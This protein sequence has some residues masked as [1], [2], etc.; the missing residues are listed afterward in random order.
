MTKPIS[1]AI[2][3][4]STLPTR[5]P[6]PMC[7]SILYRDPVADPDGAKKM[8][9]THLALARWMYEQGYKDLLKSP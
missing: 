7:H 8:L 9:E 6:V 1:A 2:C 3:V 4:C 5:A